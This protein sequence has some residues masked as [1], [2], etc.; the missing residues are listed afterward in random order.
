MTAY[1]KVKAIHAAARR[2]AN[3][4]EDSARCAVCLELTDEREQANINSCA[5][6]FCVA[7]ITTW[8]H[9]HG[10]RT[11]PCC[12]ASISRITC[13]SNDKER[14]QVTVWNSIDTP[15]DDAEEISE[16]EF[17]AAQRKARVQTMAAMKDSAKNVAK[18]SDNIGGQHG[19]GSGS[20]SGG[21]GDTSNGSESDGGYGDRL[22]DNGA[23]FND[24][25]CHE[26]E[27]EA[28]ESISDKLAELNSPGSNAH[29]AQIH[30]R[31]DVTSQVLASAIAFDK[32]RE[33]GGASHRM[34]RRSEGDA[35]IYENACDAVPHEK[36][37][38]A[39]VSE[40]VR[41][42][43]FECASC[44]CVG[45]FDLFLGR[46]Y[47]FEYNKTAMWGATAYKGHRVHT[48][49]LCGEQMIEQNQ[50]SNIRIPFCER[51]AF[52]EDLT[53]SAARAEA[54]ASKAWR[55]LQLNEVAEAASAN[56]LDIPLVEPAPSIPTIFADG[57]GAVEGKA[58]GFI[59]LD[60]QHVLH[61][62][63]KLRR[64]WS[65]QAPS[66]LLEGYNPVELSEGTV[67]RV[68][69]NAYVCGDRFAST[70]IGDEWARSKIESADL[71]LVVVQMDNSVIQLARAAANSLPTASQSSRKRHVE[72]L[73]SCLRQS[74]ASHLLLPGGNK[75]DRASEVTERQSLGA[76]F[77]IKPSDIGLQAFCRDGPAG[78]MFDAET[79]VD[80]LK[81]HADVLRYAPGQW[82]DY[83]NYTAPADVSQGVPT[84]AMRYIADEGGRARK[85]RGTGGKKS[86]KAKGDSANQPRYKQLN[87][88]IA[89]LEI[90]G[91]ALKALATDDQYMASIRVP[92]QDAAGRCLLTLRHLGFGGEPLNPGQLTNPLWTAAMT[93]QRV[94]SENLTWTDSCQY[95]ASG[96][97][98]SLVCKPMDTHTDGASRR[99]RLRPTAEMVTTTWAHAAKDWSDE[100]RLAE[101]AG[102]RAKRRHTAKSLWLRTSVALDVMPCNGM[103]LVAGTESEHLVPTPP[104]DP[105]GRNVERG[106]FTRA[107]A[108]SCRPDDCLDDFAFEQLLR[109]RTDSLRGPRRAAGAGGRAGGR[110]GAGG[111]GQRARQQVQHFVAGAARQPGGLLYFQLHPAP[112]GGWGRSRRNR[113]TGIAY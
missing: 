59:A 56:A 1:A 55:S 84:V 58:L 86:T 62:S 27:A 28:I 43:T 92:Q 87:P 31:N 71:G 35:S 30:W 40:A 18:G 99:K 98:A 89:G 15:G 36:A 113:R 112:Q 20:S 75:R 22:D 108:Q 42:A 61:A 110:A 79:A 72:T 57:S 106:G 85:V 4:S 37:F 69:A 8:C 34:K 7:C 93:W 78:G 73:R 109:R 77:G 74:A 54:T 21:N 88:P 111:R 16:A 44:Q 33:G 94:C 83:V 100:K 48:V 9:G 29:D 50:W 68:A 52:Q 5:H 26:I 23:D 6:A 17:L 102:Q 10:K 81:K 47:A 51:D 67:L 11:C 90:D 60:R 38:L 32:T 46:A 104:P 101:L 103:A 53:D 65:K 96:T 13:R 63:D 41:T 107:Y 76:A 39:G 19:D 80:S 64:L 95:M 2:A 66:A 49:A 25:I 12:R 70:K 82:G 14:K 24:E 45:R 105:E 97:R 3:E 91:D